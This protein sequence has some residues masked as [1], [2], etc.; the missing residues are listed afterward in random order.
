MSRV[1]RFDFT[2]ARLNNA[3]AR[4]GHLVGCPIV[5]VELVE[6]VEGPIPGLM[7][8]TRNGQIAAVF[9]LSDEEGNHDGSL[10]WAPVANRKES[11]T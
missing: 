11:Q 2:R 6:G 7:V 1:P 10:E 8:E 9:A 4:L 5:G 3:R